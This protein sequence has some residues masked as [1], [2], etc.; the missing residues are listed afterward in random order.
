MKFLKIRTMCTAIIGPV[1]TTKSSRRGLPEQTSNKQSSVLAL[2]YG[3]YKYK[4]Y[5]HTMFVAI[6]PIHPERMV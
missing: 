1:P 6:I 4:S 5:I 3:T 2:Q